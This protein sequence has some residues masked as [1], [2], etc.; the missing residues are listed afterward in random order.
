M[1]RDLH[2]SVFHLPSRMGL[3]PVHQLRRQLG[4]RLIVFSPGAGTAQ[5][6]L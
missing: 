3:D 2:D 4:E 1:Q 5:P 6:D